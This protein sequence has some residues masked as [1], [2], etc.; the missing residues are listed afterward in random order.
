M[1]SKSGPRRVHMS[2]LL[3]ALYIEQ[4]CRGILNSSIAGVQIAGEEVK[5]LA[6][7]DDI[8]IICASKDHV[9]SALILVDDFY[10]IS[11]AQLNKAKSVGTWLGLSGRCPNT[12]LALTSRRQ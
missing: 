6:Y 4:L 2:P 1:S 3:F 5:D 7:A 12:S 9:I 11:E 10:N 8:A